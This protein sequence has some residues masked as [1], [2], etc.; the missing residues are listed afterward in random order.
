MIDGPRTSSSP[1]VSPSHG[2]SPSSPRARI[3][4]NGIG[5]P[6]MRALVVPRGARE[7]CSWPGAP[8]IVPIGHISVMPQ[9]CVTCSPWRS[10]KASII[11]RG[12][13][14]PPT[15]IV[16]SRRDPSRRVGVERLQDP[17]PDRGHAG[18]DGD[19]LVLEVLEQ[20]HRVEVRPGEHLLRADHRAGEREAPRVG[21]EHRHDGEDVSAS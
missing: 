15:V 8:E 9:P 20:A 2:T 17:H 14:A 6:C 16:G 11:A 13:A 4:T 5:G 3:S 7:P 19:V 1:M 21:V 12:G 10:W 18:G